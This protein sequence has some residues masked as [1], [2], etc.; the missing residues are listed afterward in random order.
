MDENGNAFKN[1]L[2]RKEPQIGLWLSLSDPYCAEVVAG[3]GFDWLL[4]DGEHAPDDMRLIFAQL[5]AI[6]PYPVHPVVRPSA[7]A[8]HDFGQYFDLGVQTLLIPMV[9]N[10]DQAGELVEAVKYPLNGV[11]GTGP[12][13]AR[14]PRW[15]KTKDYPA[16]ADDEVCL[17][18]QVETVEG[19]SNIEAIAAT[20]GVDGVFIGPADL[21]ASMGYLSEGSGHPDVVAE[22]KRGFKAILAADKAPGILTLDDEMNREYLELGA[23]FLVVGAD[24]T[25]LARATE[26]LAAKFKHR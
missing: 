26:A 16:R 3:A 11:R 22:V 19:M 4:L 17:L 24:V 20:P 13:V 5:Q 8:M 14:A 25:L 12:T 10:A 7:G 15:G 9:E 6:E 21:A 2:A 1:A 18:V 23:L